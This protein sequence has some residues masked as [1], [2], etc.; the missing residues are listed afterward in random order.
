M[1]MAPPARLTSALLA[2]KGHAL[3]TGGFTRGR[4][5]PV[6]PQRAVAKPK[7]P[8]G[9]TPAPRAALSPDLIRPAAKPSGHPDHAGQPRVAFT[10]RLD[11]KRYTRLKSLA[12]RRGRSR[13]EIV[14]EALDAYL[15]ACA[16]A[17]AGAPKRTRHGKG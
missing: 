8:R 2:R 7:Q 10:V 9:G 14:I 11:R 12:A 1:T 4:P 3:P 17:S 5:G 13:Q 16:A 15:E 6:P